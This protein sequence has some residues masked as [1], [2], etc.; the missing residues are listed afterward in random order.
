[1]RIS[2]WSSDVCSSDLALRALTPTDPGVTGWIYSWLVSVP[3][4]EPLFDPLELSA[5][6]VDPSL[7]T[8][9]ELHPAVAAWF[10]ERFT[11]GP[12][13]AQEAAWPP[14]AAGSARKSAVWGTGGSVRVE[15]GG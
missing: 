11:Q 13:P 5:V 7:L 10:R 15:D 6:T 9:V 4:Q 14:I 2:D 8:S 1:M 3:V 12:T